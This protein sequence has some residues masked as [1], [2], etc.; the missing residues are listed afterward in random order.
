MSR[1][2]RAGGRAASVQRARAAAS[3]VAVGRL[4][5]TPPGQWEL[6]SGCGR[7]GT[8]CEPGQE[9]AEMETGGL[10]QVNQES[11]TQ[12]QN[13]QEELCPGLTEP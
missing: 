6:Q 12:G 3:C 13:S 10:G 1:A 5:G 9:G 11:R 8:S 7:T 4:V 2:E